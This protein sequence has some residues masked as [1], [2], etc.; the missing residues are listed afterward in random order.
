MRTPRL[1]ESLVD[2]IE[3]NAALD[4]P[5]SALSGVLRK[6]IRP[7]AVEDTLSGTPIGHPLHPLLVAVPIGAWSSSLLL[8]AVGDEEGARR[9]V[10]L[11]LVSALPTAASGASDW[12]S[13]EGAEK[14]VGLVHALFNYGAIGMYAASWF[15]RRAG[16]RGTGIGC[17]LAGASLLSA[18]G[19]LGGHLAYAQGVGVDTTAFQQ[20]PADWT[21]AL[22]VDDLPG[23]DALTSVQVAGVPVLVTVRAGRP[24]VMADR[25]THRGAPLHEGSVV[26]GCVVCPWHDS[27]F[28]LDDGS[29]QSGPANR[30]QPLLETRLHEGRLQVRRADERSLR[31]NPTGT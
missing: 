27:A 16:R 19:Y 14:R 25:C 7:G 9:L 17:S 22:A 20:Y 11:G 24:V 2:R 6:V 21:D 31:T 5:A 26:D 4:A 18:G 3:G 23:E 15:A 30:P 28:S 8:D 10:G 29:V 1:L 13:T 12:L